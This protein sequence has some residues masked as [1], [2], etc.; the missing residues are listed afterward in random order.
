MS[1]VFLPARGG[2]ETMTHALARGLPASGVRVAA[3]EEDGWRA[4]DAEQPFPV[5]RAANDPRGGRGAILRLNALTVRDALRERP[6]VLLAMHIKAAPACAVLSAAL[7]VPFAVYLHAKELPEHPRLGAFAVHHAAASI[8]VSRYTEELA[9]R[10]GAAPARLHRI[11]PGVDLPAAAPMSDGRRPILVT[12]ARLEDEN[13]GHDIVIE[14]LPRMLQAV[15]SLRW[16]VI[17][18]G[19]LRP[20]LESRARAL[21]V[22]GSVDFVGA[23]DDRTRD[24]WLGRAAVYVMPTRRPADGRGGEGF[25]I[26]YVEAAARGTPAVGTAVPGVV[27]AVEDGETGILVPDPATPE[28]VAGAVIELLADG[29]RAQRLG[30]RARRRAAS[31]GWPV[32]CAQVGAVLDS[33]AGARPVSRAGARRAR[34]ALWPVDLLRPPRG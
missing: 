25:G 4:F 32:V 8:A 13:K 31:F 14:A 24:E 12:V 21:G 34:R 28:S 11:P 27:D 22:E 1:P 29:D 19:R 18:D 30:E 15:P 20:R 16:V 10:A 5:V 17:G 26:A 6:D 9:R 2:I 3:L 23:V 7:D 33:I